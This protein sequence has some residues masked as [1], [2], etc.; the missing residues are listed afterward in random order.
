MEPQNPP[1]VP[2]HRSCRFHQLLHRTAWIHVC[3]R[4]IGNS[5]FP[6]AHSLRYSCKPLQRAVFA[7]SRWESTKW[8]AEY[9]LLTP[10]IAIG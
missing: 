10:K 6:Q 5:A 1:F 3:A 7:S 2:A 4:M 8:L 9:Q